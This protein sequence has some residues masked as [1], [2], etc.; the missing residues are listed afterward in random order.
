MTEADNDDP[1]RNLDAR[2]EEQLEAIGRLRAGGRARSALRAGMEVRRLAK[3]AKKLIPYLNAN[4]H[5]MIVAQDLLE[6]EM[7]RQSAI[8]SIALLGSAERARAFQSDYPQREYER[9]AG[10]MSACSHDHLAIATA[11]MLGYNSDA[12]QAVI[13]DGINAC[14]RTGK[15]ECIACFREYATAIFRAGDDLEMA[16]HHARTHLARAKDARTPT[17]GGSARMTRRICCC[18]PVT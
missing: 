18:W 4:F 5:V 15:L 10:W 2:M 14:R 3:A 7:S 1:T 11:S 6:P 12:V 16:L 9:M 13:A 17:G 8:E